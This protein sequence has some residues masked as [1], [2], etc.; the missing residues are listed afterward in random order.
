V[1]RLRFLPTKACALATMAAG[2]LSACVHPYR[3]PLLGEP[4]ALV[5]LR[6]SYP[7]SDRELEQSADIDGQSL[8]DLPAPT[9][10]RI[11]TTTRPV[12]PG[13]ATW[14]VRAAF[15]HNNVTSH[16]ETY[17]TT[18]P[19]PCGSS[20]CMQ[21]R[22]RTRL[23]NRVERVDDATC[24]QALKVVTKA[25][26][27]YLLEYDYVENGRC[28]LRCFQVRPRGGGATK[29]PCGGQNDTSKTP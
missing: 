11:A 23:V 25:G 9:R 8:P 19:A 20:T 1:R 10:Q 27:S 24:S 4:H 12:R 21:T 6:L 17:D 7:W 5:T 14:V 16:A 22:P 26:E 29:T 2:A 18:E 3:P 15:F 13:P 28:S